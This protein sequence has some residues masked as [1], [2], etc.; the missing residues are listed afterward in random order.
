M[1]LEPSTLDA[2]AAALSAAPIAY[3][4]ATV[5]QAAVLLADHL[6]LVGGAASVDIAAAATTDA[7]LAATGDERWA[8]EAELGAAAD[9]DDVNWLRFVHPGS[10]VWPVALGIG[11]D[12]AASGADVL[13]AAVI[14]YEAT[15]RLAV[16]L[17]PG[18]HHLTA[19]T[20]T[21]GAA[22]AVSALL[23]GAVAPDALGHAI[24]VAGGST[25]AFREL[26]GTRRFHRA[27]AA[28]AGSAAAR[29]A[30]R[31]L[32][33]T[34]TDLEFGG[35][36]WAGARV[37]ELDVSPV[38]GWAIR[39]T[40][41]RVFPT[42]GWNQAAYEAA[43][44]ASGGLT[45]AV[46][47]IATTVPGSTIAR[48]AA[49]PWN[50]LP[51]ALASGAARGFDDPR[52][53]AELIPLVTVAEGASTTVRVTTSHGSAEASVDLPSGHPERPARLEDLAA[54]WSLGLPEAQRR[55]D[56]LA[57]FLTSTRAG[58]IPPDPIRSPA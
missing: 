32:P 28:R 55:L 4:E 11:R 25:G 53:P 48:S 57:A 13:R 35:G 15:A 16:I 50:N 45:G 9:R 56:D 8:L 1:S 46:V 51:H 54:A 18:V 58:S 23:G 17:S 49:D 24:S 14:G 30:A 43:R 6:A 21:V 36:A 44:T 20:A 26:S 3:D 31:G 22:A 5:A 39:T 19:L 52:D 29:A 47:S 37:G 27:H 34:R 7:A 42:S 40:S 10:I 41:V 12:V 33:A 38:D 2:F